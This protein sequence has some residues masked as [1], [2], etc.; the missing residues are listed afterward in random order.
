[1]TSSENIDGGHLEGQSGEG[2]STGERR[3]KYKRKLMMQK[4]FRETACVLAAVPHY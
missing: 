1:M 4:N 3:C 2:A